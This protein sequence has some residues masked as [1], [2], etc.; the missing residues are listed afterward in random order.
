METT[1]EL[2]RALPERFDHGGVCFMAA[3]TELGEVSDSPAMG[4]NQRREWWLWLRNFET[5]VGARL[6]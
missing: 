2:G 6:I 5:K 4:A 1:H 3:E